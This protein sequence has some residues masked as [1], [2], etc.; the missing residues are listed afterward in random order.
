MKNADM[1]RRRLSGTQASFSRGN[2]VKAA[3]DE[4]LKKNMPEMLSK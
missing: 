3:L 4:I 2:P 1:E